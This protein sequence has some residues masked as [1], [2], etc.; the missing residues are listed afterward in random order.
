M[1]IRTYLAKHDIAWIPINIDETDGKKIPS[2]PNG[3]T[4]DWIHFKINPT[5]EQL[6]NF[7]KHFDECNAIAIDTRKTHQIDVDEMSPEFERWKEDKPWFPSFTKGYPHFFCVGQKITKN[8]HKIPGG[9]YLTGQWSYC[10]KDAVVHNPDSPM[11]VFKSDIKVNSKDPSD[12][13]KLIQKYVPNHGKTQVKSVKE[14]GSIITN[15]HYCFNV[16]R[17]HKSNHIYFKLINDK[18]YQKC[19]DPE[20]C[21]FISEPF[22]ITETIEEEYEAMT[23]DESA[24]NYIL[25]KYPNYLKRRGQYRMIYEEN[26]GIWIADDIGAFMRLCIK[27]WKD[28]NEVYGTMVRKMETLWKMALK[29]EDEEAFF[30]NAELKTQGKVLF[31]DCISDKLNNCVLDFSPEY[32]FVHQI[33]YKYP[34][35]KPKNTDLVDKFYFTQPYPEP[36]VADWLRHD[37][38]LDMYGLGSD[39]FII[40][41]GTGSNGKSRRADGIKKAIGSFAGDMSGDH[42]AVSTN[43]SASGANPQLMPLKDLR[44]AY[45]SEPRK[46]I[47]TDM[48]IIKKITG[49]DPIACRALHKGVE[50]FTSKTK[51]HF[52][53]NGMI[54]F[55]ECE[56]GFM[57]RR[58]RILESNTKYLKNI[59]EDD[60]ENQEYRADDNLARTVIDSTDALLWI[61]V[62]EPY[63]PNMPVPESIIV[64]S[65]ETIEDQDDTKK[66]FFSNFEIDPRGRVF[67]KVICDV[68]NIQP[69]LLASKMREWGFEKPKVISIDNEKASGYFGIKNKV[70]RDDY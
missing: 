32:Y 19:M 48:S 3:Y 30:K 12:I 33:P 69:R 41:I 20:C 18:L 42:F 47:I 27:T 63:N 44:L 59:Q 15:G 66:L 28:K 10:R 62:N 57:D 50:T 36:G 14:N 40:E 24:F 68:L 70:I 46:G 6:T 29:L 22:E 45:V 31:L 13:Q 53:T 11:Y 4:N 55:S 34:K 52:M 39:T 16:G 61:L 26:N 35:T 17:T 8:L 23:A 56:A 49:G 60:P 64:S 7:Q 38:M 65:R 25:S 67:S 21:D 54:K 43:T 5:K 9:D 37:K 2:L 1:D 51:I 58:L